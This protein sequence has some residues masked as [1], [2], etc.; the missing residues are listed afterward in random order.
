MISVGKL[1]VYTVV[2]G[3]NPQ[4]VLPIVIDNGTNRQELL[5]NPNY[6]GNR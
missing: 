3:I 2:A 5:D 1:A 4:H 6:V